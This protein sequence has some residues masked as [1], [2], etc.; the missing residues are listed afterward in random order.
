MPMITV[1]V[2]AGWK[3]FLVGCPLEV[4]LHGQCS[5]LKENTFFPCLRQQTESLAAQKKEKKKKI[6]CCAAPQEHN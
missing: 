5:F 1:L 4:I 6:L 2:V 3:L